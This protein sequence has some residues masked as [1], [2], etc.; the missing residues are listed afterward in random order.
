MIIL[1]IQLGEFSLWT[2]FNGAFASGR[3][4]LDYGL[5]ESPDLQ[6]AIIGVMEAL[7]YSVLHCKCI[8]SESL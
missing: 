3:E 1:E 5:R 4:S 6:D 2:A 7:D 8:S